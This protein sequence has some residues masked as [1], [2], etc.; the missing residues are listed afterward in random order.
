MQRQ[1]PFDAC[2][3]LNEIQSKYALSSTCQARLSVNGTICCPGTR[4]PGG[5]GSGPLKSRVTQWRVRVR[6]PE[7]GGYPF[8]AGTLRVAGTPTVETVKNV[9]N[10]TRCRQTSPFGRCAINSASF[11]VSTRF[12]SRPPCAEGRGAAR[13]CISL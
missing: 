10:L 3:S 9:A 2:S 12:F 6:P 8:V 4:V 1:V 7:F 11:D 5:P 13:L